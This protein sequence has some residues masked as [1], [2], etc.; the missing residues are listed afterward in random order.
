MVPV[1]VGWQASDVC[2]P[3]VTVALVSITSSEP[4][5]AA[6]DGDGRTTGDVADASVGTADGVVQLRAERSGEGPGR[7]YE[8]TYLARDASGNS[9]SALALVTVPHDQ[10]SGPEP[11]IM[12]LEQDASPGMAHL[13]W[14]AVPGAVSYDLISGD[15]ESL[16]VRDGH[17]DLG[18]VRVFARGTAGTSYSEGATDMLPPAGKG[19]FYL[20]QSSDGQR[21]SGYGTETAFWPSEPASCD[22]GC[23]GEPAATASSSAPRK[24]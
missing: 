2:D 6:G 17:I 10:G 19:Y 23:P 13:Y 15:L 5:D 3:A 24:K 8:I 9:A 18:A 16:A 14:S 1:Q 20:L 7:T 11:L 12:R 4:D 22:G 21:A